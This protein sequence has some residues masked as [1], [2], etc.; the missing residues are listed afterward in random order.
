MDVQTCLGNAGAPFQIEWNGKKVTV[1]Y[2]V[3][4]IKAW[5][6]RWAKQQAMRDLTEQK[7]FMDPVD[8]T[9]R[10]RELLNAFKGIGPDGEPL[11]IEVEGT[12]EKGET[13]KVAVPYDYSYESPRLAAL[14]STEAGKMAHTRS[15]LQGAEDWTESEL[16][17][18]LLD[19]GDELTGYVEACQ[20][21]VDELLKDL[22]A[23]PDPKEV[24]R[25][26]QRAGLW[27]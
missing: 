8:F 16:M 2:R 21:R 13:V 24:A 22:G 10:Q 15:M 1:L 26:L 25:R 9:A 23:K 20:G 12:N 11:T 17:L 18:F 19:K 4:R 7:A 5:F 14:R 3:Q 6:E 27:E